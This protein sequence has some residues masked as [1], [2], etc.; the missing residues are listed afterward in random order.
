MDRSPSLSVMQNSSEQSNSQPSLTP[1]RL[2]I[3]TVGTQVVVFVGFVA[4]QLTV[5]V[6]KTYSVPAHPPWHP[7]L[8]L[9]PVYTVGTA[10]GHPH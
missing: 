6:A 5:S 1:G 8:Q 3:V 9:Y 2:E 10:A 4:S 7:S